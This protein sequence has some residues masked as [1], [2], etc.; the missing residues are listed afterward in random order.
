MV[1]VDVQLRDLRAVAPA[2]VLYFKL[3]GDL[4][5]VPPPG[6]NFKFEYLNVV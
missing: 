6:T 2:G 5:F 3:R 1:L 4:P